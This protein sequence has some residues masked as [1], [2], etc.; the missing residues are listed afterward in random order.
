[1]ATQEGENV[2]V[3]AINGNFDDAQNGVKAIFTDKAVAEKLAENNI[4]F[5]SANSINWGRL[6]PQI[7]YYISAYGN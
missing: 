2:C 7:I 4:M 6:V 3:C 5:S 1:M